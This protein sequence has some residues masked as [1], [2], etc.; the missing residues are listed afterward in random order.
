[1]F[2][3]EKMRIGK[4][5]SI[6]LF[7][8]MLLIRLICALVLVFSG[9]IAHAQEV[10]PAT[11]SATDANVKIHK[12]KRVRATSPPR[13]FHPRFTDKKKRAVNVSERNSKVQTTN[14]RKQ[15]RNAKFRSGGQ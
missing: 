10:A 5:V 8:P 9:I 13:E 14:K 11:S 3:T 7:L 1:M 4:S 15:K 12:G 2:D 6:M